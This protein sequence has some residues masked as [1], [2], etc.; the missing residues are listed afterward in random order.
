MT[1]LWPTY[2]PLMGPPMGPHMEQ[3]NGTD[4]WN[5]LMEQANGATHTEFQK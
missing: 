4:R 1:H 3:A 5:K 2:D